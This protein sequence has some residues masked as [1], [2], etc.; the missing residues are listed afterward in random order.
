MRLAPNATQDLILALMLTC[1]A[2]FLPM[3]AAQEGLP[4]TAGVMAAVFAIGAV[5]FFALFVIDW[6]KGR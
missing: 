4:V 1:Y 6:R 5:F 2:I 3:V